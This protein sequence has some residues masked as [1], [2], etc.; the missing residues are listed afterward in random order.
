MR[1]LVILIALFLTLMN[2]GFS[3]SISLS[4]PGN[5]KRVKAIDEVKNYQVIT[6]ENNEFLPRM[7][8]G[9]GELKGFF[10]DD[11]LVKMETKVYT[12]FGLRTF[13]YYYSDDQLF[14]IN[15]FFEHFSYEPK[16]GTI[17]YAETEI[18]FNGHYIFKNGQ[19]IDYETTGHNRFENAEIDPAVV[20]PVEANNYKQLL[21]K[22]K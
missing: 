7:T 17:N 16:T 1:T 11:H 13:K 9:G 19:L 18:T 8:D 22:K 5:F 4:Y 3:Q 14:Y 2:A 12:S 10:T 20:L 15:E 21:K 6:L